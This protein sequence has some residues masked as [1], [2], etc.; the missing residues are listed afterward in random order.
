MTNGWTCT[1]CNS[2]NSV[3]NVFCVNCGERSTVS[4]PTTNTRAPWFGTVI[5]YA[6]KG[7]RVAH[8][9]DDYIQFVKPKPGLGWIVFGLA[10][11]GYPFSLVA[12]SALP[13]LG[14][15]GLAIVSLLISLF[16]FEWLAR[17]E[18]IVTFYLDQAGE[19]QRIER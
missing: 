15:I 1:K 17:R 3:G 5:S 6:L 7:Y 18:I 13:Q 2:S 12:M 4:M 10:M 9:T 8:V 16:F 11:I 19:I 14:F